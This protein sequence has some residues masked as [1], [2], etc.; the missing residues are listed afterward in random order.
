MFC[1]YSVFLYRFSVFLYVN[2]Y[3][4]QENKEKD[5]KKEVSGIDIGQGTSQINIS[6]RTGDY[7]KESCKHEIL[8]LYFRN[9]GHKINK[10]KRNQRC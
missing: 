7:A 4:D 3:Q 1:D 2:T 6:K 10:V 5:G 8:I 9:A